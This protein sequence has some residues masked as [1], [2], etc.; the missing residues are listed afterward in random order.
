MAELATTGN[1][2]R[3]QSASGYDIVF[4]GEADSPGICV[5]PAEPCMLAHEIELDD[6]AAGR[7]VAWV[8]VPSL[9][10]GR[11]LHLYYGNNQITSST[12]ANGAVFDADYVG[13]WHLKETG[14]GSRNEYRD[15][16]RYANHGQGGQGALTR[17]R[18]GSAGRSATASVLT[19]R[20]TTSPT[21]S[22][23][24]RTAR[25]TSPATRSPWKAG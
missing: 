12:E 9:A 2:G 14:T 3:V 4:R 25:S 15:S 8:R 21:S 6:G 20:P 13:V 17:P 23:S 24:A 22:T 10:N 11:I 5:P 16:S 18:R 1:G 7:V 19:A